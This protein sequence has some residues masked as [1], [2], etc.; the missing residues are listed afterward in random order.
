MI[1]QSKGTILIVDDQAS[2]REVMR[3]FLLNEGY[4]LAFAHD[5][6]TGLA[7]AAQLNPDL[8]LLDVMMPGMD[9]FE[10]CRQLRTDP[11]LADVLII[12][13]T[14]KDDRQS[15]LEGLEA[16]ADDF[17]GK[18]VDYAEFITRVRTMTRLN[19]HRRLRALE[20]QLERDRTQAILDT[21]G[22]AVIVTDL[23]GDIQYINPVTVALTGYSRNE[24]LGRNW[25]LG[26]SR[27]T[28]AKFDRRMLDRLLT[29]QTW[30]GEITITRKDGSTYEAA[31][32]V[33]PLF[34]SHRSAT[35]AISS[36]VS[37]HR[38]I[39]PLKQAER[40]KNEFV[41][42]VS[43]EL[44]TPLS[45]ITLL[46]DNLDS[47]YNYLLDD[48][49][50][51]M[52]RDIQKH[53]E[54]LNNLISDVL[55]LS[56][57][58]SGRLPSKREVVDLAELAC[59]LVSEIQPLA[60]QSAHTLT[61]K[62]NG[63]LPVLGHKAQLQQVVRNLLN[64]AIKYTSDG[65]YICCETQALSPSTVD[66]TWPEA[67]TLPTGRWVALKVTDNGIGIA[68]EHLAHIFER[69]YRVKAE[70]KIRGT[71]LGL[72]ICRDLID[73]H[74]GRIAVASEPGRGST[75][76]IYLPLLAEPPHP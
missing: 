45:V 74:Q 48:K 39:T 5:G 12:M 16:G 49:R 67:A 26:Q 58:D 9:G 34:S 29:G 61:V 75:F 22:E 42:N 25:R 68:R 31:L 37:V 62:A 51:Q 64:N 73:L 41:S 71:G 70:H 11:Q 20:L 59:E 69:F 40:S 32:T 2:A 54:V 53:A 1:G 50:R 19:R 38:D 14:A 15:R 13:I 63:A 47:L 46:S 7:Q 10:V 57:I 35:T 6:P 27:E 30:Y 18:P 17:L 3:G 4:K 60:Q 21:L 8:I 24:L 43:H 76:A 52:V 33:A 65:G 36:F 72:S 28:I 55:E 23:N 66:Q 56:R 44:R